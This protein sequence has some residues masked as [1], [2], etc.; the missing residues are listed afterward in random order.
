M[1]IHADGIQGLGGL[2]LF[3]RMRGKKRL[4]F[5]G[6]TGTANV[7]IDGTNY[8]ATFATD[9]SITAA[10]FVT[11][12]AAAILSAEGVTV[13]QIASSDGLQFEKDTIDYTFD[14]VN[15]TG[16]IAQVDTLT[17]TGTSGAAGITID[18]TTRSAVFVS[19]L[20]QTATDYVTNH[21]AAFLTIG[22]VI[23]SSV[24]DIIFTADSPGVSFNSPTIANNQVGDL[25]GTIANTTANVTG[26]EALLLT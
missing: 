25:D 21:A 10:N 22:I 4:R 3:K 26:V 23:T 19:S 17:L 18:T 6:T 20:T 9:L 16:N 24:A 1:T 8:L 7:V 15:V 14:V 13:T 2:I 11:T 12:H 5:R